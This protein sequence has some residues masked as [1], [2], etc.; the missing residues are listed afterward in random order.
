MTLFRKI[1]VATDFSPASDAAFEAAV[2][3]ARESG[4][5]L[6]IFHAYD[7]PSSV[8]YAPADLYAEVVAAVRTQ[9]EEKLGELTRGMSATGAEIK[10]VLRRGIP[11]DAIVQ[12]ANREDVDL[13]VMGT[14]GRRGAARLFLGSV[15]A[16][17]V[18]TAS[19][20]VLTIRGVPPVIPMQRT[21]TQIVA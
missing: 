6:Y 21:P 1:L 7:S 10:P 19:C 17:V 9:A 13:I 16:R 8:A 3:L 12:A 11:E 14:H 18:A 5:T 4:A 20:P 2:G 15:A